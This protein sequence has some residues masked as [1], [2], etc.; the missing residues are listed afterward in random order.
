MK[1]WDFAKREIVAP[2][3][4][5][6]YFHIISQHLHLHAGKININGRNIAQNVFR[7]GVY[8]WENGRVKCLLRNNW[9]GKYWPLLWLNWMLLLLLFHWYDYQDLVNWSHISL[10]LKEYCWL[11]TMCQCNYNTLLPPC[12][13]RRQLRSCKR[14]SIDDSNQHQEESDNFSILTVY[15][16][17]SGWVNLVISIDIKYK[18]CQKTW[19]KMCYRN[20]FC[21]SHQDNKSN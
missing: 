3:I 2:W 14:I 7:A 4:R 10:Q 6:A 11:I 19:Y 16:Q 5:D 17:L 20:T 12:H 1:F 13:N 8:D 21:E 18:W 15:S 9:L